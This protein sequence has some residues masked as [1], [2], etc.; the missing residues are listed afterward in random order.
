VRLFQHDALVLLRLQGRILRDTLVYMRHSLVPLLVMILP[1]IWI[2]TQLNLRFTSRP[3]A[4]GERTVLKVK[5]RDAAALGGPIALEASEGVEVETPPVRIASLREAAWRVRVDSPGR[6]RV[7]VVLG[8]ERLEKSLAAGGGWAA[9]SAR[10]TGAGPLDA[11]LYPGEPPIAP[12][13]AIESIE[14]NYDSASIRL[15]G[16]NWNWIVFFFVFSL[17]FGFLFKGPMGVEI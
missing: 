7:T 8:E 13:S 16:L 14:V 15:F 2:M 1:A 9:V 12:A 17:I 6:H 5:V 3:L 11:L 4:P 10:R